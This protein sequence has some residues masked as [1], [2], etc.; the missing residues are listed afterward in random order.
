MD[1]FVAVPDWTQVQ[2]K[3][4]LDPLGLQ[5]AN[6]RLYQSLVP[7]ISNITL[8]T[9]YYGFYAWLCKDYAVQTHN[10]DPEIWKKVVR[11]AEALYAL[12]AAKAN[13]GGAQ[14]SGVAGI[15]WAQRKLSEHSGGAIDFSIN[16]DPGG[17][18]AAYLK[19]SRGAFGAAYESQ[20][21][22]TGVLGSADEH[23][24]SVPTEEIGD[25]M[26]DA[27]AQAAGGAGPKFL[28]IVKAGRVSLASLDDLAR[29]LPSTIRAQSKERAVYERM[30]F[31]EFPNANE[32]DVERRKTLILALR[33]AK[34][35]KARPFPDDVRWMLY[36]GTDWEGVA[37]QLP[38][39]PLAAQRQRWW[40]YQ[41]GDLGRVAYESLLKWLLDVLETYPAG[42]GA[43]QLAHAAVDEMELAK[44]GWP[45][46]WGKL[47]SN[48]PTAK[49]PLSED[50]AT[51]EFALTAEVLQAG[52]DERRAPLRSALAAVELLAVLFR[53]CHQERAFLASQFGG[54]H[55]EAAGRSFVNE[56]AF[57]GDQDD[58]PVSDLLVR[59]FKER[60]LNR[61]LWVAMRKLQY[62]R[63]YTFLVETDDGRVRL[64]AKDGPVLTNPRLG[65]ALTF[66]RDIHL[67]DPNGLTKRGERLAE[68]V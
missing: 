34:R 1:D 3:S 21:T 5:A 17:S 35:L 63:D 66:L 8:R 14:E 44:T 11:R 60:I 36:A 23:D 65:P 6:V 57:L 33:V 56:L 4:G 32:H 46:T 52:T 26:A 7:G 24:L 29:L 15:N 30:L 49:N 19:Q 62:Q 43:D 64:R 16:A 18:G 47:V 25:E 41:A 40:A 22:E 2:Q 67:V 50:E 54:D 48:L 37:L 9:R 51:A 12:T 42:L 28:K 68:S 10:A 45:K 59:I 39:P 27:F 55:P 58:T 53:K 61:H 20:L 31:A 13:K 38:E